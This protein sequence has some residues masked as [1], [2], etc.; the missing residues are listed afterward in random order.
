[1]RPAYALALVPL[2]LCA[3]CSCDVK[4]EPTWGEPYRSCGDGVEHFVEY[5][6]YVATAEWGESE[7]IGFDL[8]E[9]V[10][11]CESG[12]I[13]DGLEGVDNRMWAVLDGIG[14]TFGGG[15]EAVCTIPLCFPQQDIE[16]GDLSILIKSRIGVLPHDRICRE[17][18]LY[19][20]R[21]LDGDPS[22]NL[23]GFEPFQASRASIAEDGDDLIEHALFRFDTGGEF[24]EDEYRPRPADRVDIAVR[25][26][27]GEW[28]PI[29]F[30]RAHISITR[31][32]D[33]IAGMLS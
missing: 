4:E 7:N 33:G 28:V 18:Y 9:E 29:P 25:A 5:D 23:S 17:Y 14:D 10:T 20:G 2:L 27:S 8:D 31:T 19:S 26:P 11:S 12:C 13:N 3:S 22:D 30:H 32:V 6:Y 15:L 16:N 1:M 24:L 21:D